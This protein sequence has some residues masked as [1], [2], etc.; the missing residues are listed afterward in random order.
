[1]ADPIIK[2][3]GS[4]HIAIQTRDWEKSLA[5]YRDLLGFPVVAQGGTPDRK[6]W[7]LDI[8]DGSHIELFEPTDNTPK[9]GDDSVNDSFTH[10]AFRT[11]NLHEVIEYLQAAGVEITR[12]PFDVT[13]SPIEATVAFFNGP[14][15]E[16]LELFQVNN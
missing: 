9:P 8:G 10:F 5:F 12:G 11:T 4:H 15:G 7:L 16:V 14:D 13:L 1:M 6:V 2:G 3:A